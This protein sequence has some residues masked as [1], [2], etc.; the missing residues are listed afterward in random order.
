[1]GGTERILVVDDEEGI[2][3]S[4][5]RV[6]KLFGYEVEEAAD[7][8]AALAILSGSGAPFDLVLSDLVMPRM[9]GLALYEELWRRNVNTRALLMSGYTAEDVRALTGVSPSVSF[10]NKPWS[11]TDLLRRVREVLD[12]PPQSV[13]GLRCFPSVSRGKSDLSSR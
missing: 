9:G 10:L 8:K 5:M 12:E 2:R 7:G 3:R 4:A 13:A 1:V 6:L 11:V